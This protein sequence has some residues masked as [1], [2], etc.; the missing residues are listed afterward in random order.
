MS[1]YDGEYGQSWP[2]CRGALSRLRPSL[3]GVSYEA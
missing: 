2:M 1:V 3:L